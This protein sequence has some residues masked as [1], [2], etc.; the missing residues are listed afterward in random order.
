MKITPEELEKFKE[1]VRKDY[2][3]ELSDA[4]A[5]EQAIALFKL[6]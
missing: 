4:Q 3:I 2:E 1:I 6:F 5:T